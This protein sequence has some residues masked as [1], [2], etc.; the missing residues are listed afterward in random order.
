MPPVLAVT[1][2]GGFIGVVAAPAFSTSPDVV[3][4]EVY[5]GGGNSGAPYLNDFVELYN[6]GTTAV[7]VSGWSTQ[8][9]SASGTNYLVTALSGT[10]QPGSRYLVKL[11]SGGSQGAA[12]P[13]PDA[14]GTT[15][16]SATSGKVA[17]V[18]TTTALT[19]GGNCDTASGVKDFIGYGS[20][21]DYETS[22]APTLS[23]TTSATRS[24]PAT[25]TDNNASDFAKVSPTPQNSQS[26]G[27]GDC[28]GYTT[29]I[30]DI[31]GS[32]HISSR[33]GQSVSNVRGVV[34]TVIST[35]FW[36]QDP[37]PDA[38]NATS[39]GVFVY[40]S[41]APTVT[42]GQEIAVGGTVSEYRPGGSS[43]TNLT[44]TE[45][46]S[47][48]VSVLGTRS[49][50]AA[51]VI[52]TGGRVPP[53]TVIDNDATGS[54]ETSG[55]FD[56]ST[57]GIDFYE[58]L[59]GMRVQ[60]NNPVAV[61]PGN[62]YNEIPVLG[63]NGANASVRTT[64]G[65][66][67]LRQTDPNPERVI[68]DDG[69]LT[70]SVPTGV[71]VGDHFSGPAVGILD[72]S[73]GNFKL[74]LTSAISRVAGGLAP[75]S[76]GGPGPGQ[77]SVATF[78]VEN[79]DP[80]DPQSKFDGL[81]QQI[82]THLASPGIITV[83][84]IQDN[85]GATNSSVVAADQTWTK[86]INAI[87]AAGGPT[88]TYQQINP[89]DDADGG[90]PGGNIRVGFLFRTDIGLTFASGTP[91]GSTTAVSVSDSGN[92]ADRVNLSVNPGRIDPTNSAF[93]ASRKPLVGKFYFSS[94]PLFVI[95][96]HWNSKGGDNPLFGRYQ[97]PTLSSETQRNQQA[98]VV[99]NFVQSILAIDSQARIVVAGDLNDFTYSAPVQ[100]L[101]SAGLT[102]LPATLAD[103]ERYTYVYDGNSQ[104]LDHI[105]LSAALAGAS[106]SYDV[107]HVNSEFAVQQSDHDPQVARLT[108]P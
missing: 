11:G 48:S 25:D 85:D 92:P 45:I 26:G 100:T 24:N 27:G 82:V 9:A 8:Y 105:L 55:T 70:G 62:S 102:D 98:A 95:A 69:A 67:V 104:V 18:T 107:V 108:L 2:V 56:A 96:N 13:T 29:R 94:K 5:G 35:G 101:A 71:N 86:L 37:C 72:Y 51:T 74:L 15:N 90:E 73:F 19:C 87:S 97:P 38:N 61:G 40:T 93:N 50:P 31:Q 4:S 7:S 6:R 59:E 1:L 81:A 34:T 28:A 16:M 64:R 47:P 21:N 12:L 91:G 20:A 23:N 99:K 89:V 54:V 49:V 14:T 103:A 66:I 22:P 68:L 36:F 88:Y 57:D 84:E 106:Y 79:L 75:E 3:I 58:S 41:S 76:T 39:E 53:S 77:I 46:T 10:I 78:N 32:A 44:T 42:V 30:R 83:E 63:D 65:G 80:S 17:L 43:T 52:G 33:N 60:V